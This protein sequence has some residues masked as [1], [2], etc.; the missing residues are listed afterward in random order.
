MCPGTRVPLQAAQAAS[1]SHVVVIFHLGFLS[2]EASE[3]CSSL[4]AQ[5]WQV[6][7][8]SGFVMVQSTRVSSY[9]E[10]GANRPVL[11]NLLRSP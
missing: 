7:S 5:D 4:E 11:I 1:L 2:R 3:F 10:R 8:A 9:V 6:P